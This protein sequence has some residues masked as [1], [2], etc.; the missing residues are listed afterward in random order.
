[1]TT[2]PQKIYHPRSL[3][4]PATRASHVLDWN[5]AEKYADSLNNAFFGRWNKYLD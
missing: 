1:M 5:K 3:R 2:I 4:F